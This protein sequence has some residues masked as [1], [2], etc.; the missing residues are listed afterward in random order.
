[1]SR[2]A[3]N[4]MNNRSNTRPSS[5]TDAKLL[6]ALQRATTNPANQQL[7]MTTTDQVC[8]AAFLGD[9]NLVQLLLTSGASINQCSMVSKH[10]NNITLYERFDLG[11]SLTFVVTPHLYHFFPRRA[12]L[13]CTKRSMAIT[14]KQLNCC[15]PKG[16]I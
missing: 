15:C 5:S 6:S 4:N 14:T 7:G 9:D 11:A 8:A 10:C 3:N 12:G 13:R 16:V 2:V 1:M